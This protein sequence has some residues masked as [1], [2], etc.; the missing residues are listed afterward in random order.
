M[1]HTKETPMPIVDDGAFGRCPNC[2][3]VF[4]SELLNEYDMEY[5]IHCGQHLKGDNNG[6]FVYSNSVH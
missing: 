4:N 1:Q 6:N 3:F 5:C 2:G